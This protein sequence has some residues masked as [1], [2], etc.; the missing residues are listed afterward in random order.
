MQVEWLTVPVAHAG[1]I[2]DAPRLTESFLRVLN[3]LLSIVGI[4]AILSLVVAGLIYSTAAGDEKRIDFAKKVT[5]A[6]DIGLIVALG[7]WVILNQLLQ[8]FS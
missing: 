8:F 3:F 6:A 2:S 1:A 5:G 4:V 7:A